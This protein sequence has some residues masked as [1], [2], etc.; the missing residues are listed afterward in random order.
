MTARKHTH[1][2]T[3]AH[4]HVIIVHSGLGQRNSTLSTWHVFYVQPMSN[5]YKHT[6]THTLSDN[7][8]A[9][10]HSAVNLHTIS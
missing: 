1:T 7:G 9:L 5:H 6:H 10:P 3:H 2:H 4:T 8:T